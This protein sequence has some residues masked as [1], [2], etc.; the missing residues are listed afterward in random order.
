VRKWG[1]GEAAKVTTV[2]TVIRNVVIISNFFIS[3]MPDVQRWPKL[4]SYH[5]HIHPPVSNRVGDHSQVPTAV[6]FCSLL[7]VDLSLFPVVV[8]L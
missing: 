3:N 8:I 4:H 7:A 1:R 2:Y 5:V 6:C